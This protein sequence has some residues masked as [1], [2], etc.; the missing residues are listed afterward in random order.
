[1]C[2]FSAGLG[3]IVVANHDDA[4]LEAMLRSEAAHDV[5]KEE[6]HGGQW[7]GQWRKRASDC[8]GNGM[9]KGSGDVGGETGSR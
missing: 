8:S 9:S 5:D 2:I 7:R 1:M 4:Y 6:G 3:C